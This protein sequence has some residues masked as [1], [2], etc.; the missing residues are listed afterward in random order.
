MRESERDR[1]V[2]KNKNNNKI[3]KNKNKIKNRKKSYQHNCFNSYQKKK[4]KKENWGI[5]ML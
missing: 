2:K 1:F 4:K 3:K 5:G